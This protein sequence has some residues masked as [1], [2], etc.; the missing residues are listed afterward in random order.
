MLC[1][2]VLIEKIVPLLA[3]GTRAE[4]EGERGIGEPRFQ[5]L[6]KLCALFLI[7]EAQKRT[8]LPAD[9]AVAV[10]GEKFGAAVAFEG[11]ELDIVGIVR[12]EKFVERFQIRLFHDQIITRGKGKSKAFC[13]AKFAK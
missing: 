7:R 11:G 10:D 12:R 4:G 6:H 9:V 3:E 5:R 2:R 13:A 8:V 1:K